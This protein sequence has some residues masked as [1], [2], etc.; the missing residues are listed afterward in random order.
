MSDNF[1]T[2]DRLDKIQ[3]RHATPPPQRTEKPPEE[4]SA[5]CGVLSIHAHC[6][7][8]NT[9]GQILGYSESSDTTNNTTSVQEQTKDDSPS[10]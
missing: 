2:G 7:P 8:N 5:V 10:E 4:G 1:R 6:D 9:L 3:R